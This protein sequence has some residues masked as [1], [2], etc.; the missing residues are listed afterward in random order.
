MSGTDDFD[1]LGSG[2][3][4]RG[5]VMDVWFAIATGVISG[6]ISAA[7]LFVARTLIAG[8][9]LPWYHDLVYRGINVDGRWHG[10]AFAMAQDISITIKQRAGAIAGE[11][12]LMKRG[13]DAADFEEIREFSVE[14][15]IQDRYITLTLSHKNRQRIGVI[16]FLLE[17]VCDGRQLSGVMS[18][19][20]IRAQRIDS[21]E[22][23]LARDKAIVDR[24]RIEAEEAYERT[25]EMAKSAVGKQQSVRSGGN[26]RA[27]KTSEAASI[28]IE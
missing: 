27:R 20:S 28:E 21:V 5:N 3:T 19:V 2:E 8:H 23:V 14:G 26:K 11:A 13:N 7:I 18:F 16:A 24:L 17:P 4:R 9:L 22:M 12:Q 10:S 15:R 1:V 25:R 6:A